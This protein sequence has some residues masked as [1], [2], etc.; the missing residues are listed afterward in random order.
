M[1]WDKVLVLHFFDAFSGFC[2]N[3]DFHALKMM[4][5]TQIFKYEIAAVP[6]Y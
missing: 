6:F 4:D 2:E 3:S 1:G 5:F